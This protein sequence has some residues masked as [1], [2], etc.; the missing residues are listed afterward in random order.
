MAKIL[1][2]SD[3]HIHSHKKS[4]NRLQDCL[5][6][7]EWVFET[8]KKHSIES[9]VFVGD[10]FHDREQIDILTY[11]LTFD[12][13][14]KH[15][16]GSLKLYLLLG[17]H[18]LWYYDKWDV[19]SVYP[20]SALPNTKVINQ[21]CSLE[22]EDCLIDFLPYVRDPIEH[23]GEWTKKLKNRRGSKILFSHLAI[24]DAT[25]NKFRN[26]YADVIVEHDGEMMHVDT[27]LLSAWDKVWLGH[28]HCQQ[29][30]SDVVEYVGSPLELTFNEAFQEKHIV[31]YDLEDGSAEYI[32][33][34][35]SPKHLIISEEEIDDYD[36]KN[37]FVKI[38]TK[39]SSSGIIDLKNQISELAPSSLEIV[40]IVTETTTEIAD[41]KS[42]L[43]DEDKMLERYLEQAETGELDGDKLLGIGK[44]IIKNAQSQLQIS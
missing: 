21:S 41:A 1:I 19:S 8:A 26:T 29:K 6:V 16:D 10:L 39:N 9:I 27:G 34:D 40:P 37:N 42:I 4:F 2:F 28:Y 22:I 7:L 38:Q 18:D 23:L 17:N 44:E 5:K 36:L 31:I 43:L 12:T 3:I 11:N 14:S 30:V 20:F 35:F 25:L 15:L 33:N 24:H 13:F 32:V